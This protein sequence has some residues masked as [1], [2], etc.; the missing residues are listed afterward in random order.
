MIYEKTVRV[1]YVDMKEQQV[2]IVEREDLKQYMGGVGVASK[3]L[4]ETMRPELSPLDPAQPIVFA[5]GAL[6]TIYPV[7]TKAVA[8]FISPLTGELGE[9][10][11]GGRL[12]LSMF[13]A[14]FDAIVIVNRAA[15]PTYL[16]ISPHDVKFRDARPLWGSEKDNV[17]RIIRDEERQYAGKRSIIRIGRGGE[18]QVSYACVSV[19]RYRHFG[20]MGLGAVFGSKHL[21]AISVVGSREMLIQ[22]FAKYFKVYRN[23]YETCTKSDVMAKYHDTGTPINV[24]PLN[25]AGALPTLNMQQNRFEHADKIS[26]ETFS[27]EYLVRKVAC[28]GCPVG[29]IHIGQFRREFAAHG[30]EYETVSVGY[31]YELIFALGTFLGIGDPKDIL[32]LIEDVELAGLDAMSTGVVLGWATEA[33][34]RGLVSLN[35]TIVPLKFGSSQGYRAAVSYIADGVNEFYKNLGLG[36][37]RASEI[38]GGEDFAM[39]VAGNEMAGYH[40]GY[41][42]LIGA[43]VGARHS[44]LCNGGY[45]LD[46]G[47][48]I[49]GEV[50]PDEMAEAL[51]KEE[52]ERCMLNSL[53]IC[54][55]SRKVYDRETILSAFAGI[56][57]EMTDDDLTAIARRI[58]AVKLRIKKRMGFDLQDIRLP[59]RFFETPSMH[60]RLDEDLAREILMKYREKIA[61]LE[62]VEEIE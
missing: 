17:G 18:N 51:L 14:G 28:S 61:E 27:L 5:I 1:L 54:L 43:A 21:K 12:A 42:S 50:N 23:I 52:L 13:S 44:H 45:S 30:H 25:A 29:C 8:M 9:T 58:Y 10:Y 41:G 47:L 16:A 31:D 49:D 3:L 46:Q 39:Q 15:K 6:S 26:G 24:A 11:A 62:S 34:E 33:L 59:K 22:D 53:T 57:Q 48:P 36:V 19:D 35:D 20:R 7:I 60:G 55:F 37:K 40:T 4:E 2:L 56:G 32:E 38:Y